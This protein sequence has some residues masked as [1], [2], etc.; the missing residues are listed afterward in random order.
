VNGRKRRPVVSELDDLLARLDAA[1]PRGVTYVGQAV[2]KDDEHLHLAVRE[3]VI[4]I[5]I[6]AIAGVRPYPLTP[7]PNVV[8]VEVPDTSGVTQIR[9]VSPGPEESSDAAAGEALFTVEERFAGLHGTRTP[10][11]EPTATAV[12]DEG[13]AL[14]GDDFDPFSRIDDVVE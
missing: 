2:G 12:I 14:L 8:S 9:R 7:V 6:A 10:A 13:V 4:A 3:G 11:S 5:P 1:S